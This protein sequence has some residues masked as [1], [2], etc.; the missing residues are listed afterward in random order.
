MRPIDAI[1]VPEVLAYVR[2]RQPRP[3]IGNLLFPARETSSL[4]WEA[5]IGADRASVAAKVVAFDNEASIASR[6]GIELQRGKI[7]AI[8]RKISLGEET[9]KKLYTPRPQTSEFDDAVREIYDDVENMISAVET[10]IEMFRFEAINTGQVLINEDG[11]IQQVQFGFRANQQSETLTGG[12][13]WDTATTA[14][15]IADM[16]RWRE[17]IMDNGG[18]EPERALTSSAQIANIIRSNEV[19]A[20][21]HGTLGAGQ[22]VTI[23]QLNGLLISMGLPQIASYD[24]RYRTQAENG[25]YTQLRFLPVDKFI[26][27][28]GQPL[29]ETLYSPTVEALKKV[30]EGIINYG[31]TRGI[32]AEVWEENEPPAHWTKAAALSFP[33][34]PMVDSIFVA[35]VE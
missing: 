19:S 20:L 12:A 1:S 17:A 28:P 3:W 32:Y 31:D 27:L 2:A 18:V 34:F 8:K 4:E 6:E 21:I 22:P 10:R 14:T 23:P 29:G 13:T 5:I 15:P 30:R 11:V 33:T 35:T 16:Q 24:A 7:P 26:M 25:V 9:M